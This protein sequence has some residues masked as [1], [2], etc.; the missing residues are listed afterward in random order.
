MVHRGRRAAH[1]QPG[2]EQHQAHRE[3]DRRTHAVGGGAGHD[4]A[5]QVA[6]EERA[7]D[8]AVEPEVA[9][10]L[11]SLHKDQQTMLVVV[12]HSD[13]LA[14]RFQRRFEVNNRALAAVP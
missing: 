2:G 3:R 1:H 5:D 4:D 7:E 14:S 10:V 8:P 12:T 9:E 13:S 6:Q 11:L